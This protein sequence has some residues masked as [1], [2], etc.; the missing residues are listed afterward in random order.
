MRDDYV[1]ERILSGHGARIINR[2]GFNGALNENW[3]GGFYA[4]T[5][6]NEH[7]FARHY[8]LLR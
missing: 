1:W 7:L 4:F 3:I 8:P 2:V 6:H 5:P